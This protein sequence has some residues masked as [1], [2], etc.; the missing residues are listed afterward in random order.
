MSRRALAVGFWICLLCVVG[1]AF[2]PARTPMPS[3]GS[4]KLNHMLAFFVLGCLGVAAWPNA[5]RLVA[6]GLLFVGAGIE[7]GQSLVSYRSGE[8]LDFVSDA[9]GVSL[10]VA[11]LRMW[12]NRRPA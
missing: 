9:V 3:T 11:A 1:L 8:L 4:D 6:F 12:Q 5:A 2:A 7:V 10:A